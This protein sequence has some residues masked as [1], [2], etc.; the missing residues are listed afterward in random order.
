M[1]MGG[2]LGY[3]MSSMDSLSEESALRLM[4]VMVVD[5][6]HV[7]EEE[8]MSQWVESLGETRSLIIQLCLSVLIFCGRALVSL[9]WVSSPS[10]L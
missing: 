1:I 6:L 4:G 8:D 7:D 5:E 10:L 2:G 3:S 9:M